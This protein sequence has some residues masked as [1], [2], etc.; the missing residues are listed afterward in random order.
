MKRYALRIEYDGTDFIGWQYQK[1]G[2]SV[3]AVVDS[4][5]AQAF[6]RRARTP[7]G[8]S[9]AVG[10]ARTDAGVHAQFQVAHLDLACDLA[11]P[12]VA[13]V[14]NEHLPADCAVRAAVAVPPDFHA[15]RD[16]RLKRYTYSLSD[17]ARPVIERRATAW[18][19]HPLDVS[20]MQEAAQ[21]WIGKHDF[22]AFRDARCEAKS[23]ERTISFIQVRREGHIL[24]VFEARS[25]LHRQVRI[26][27][28][29]LVEIGR[30]AK[31]AAW[32]KERLDGRVRA[33]SGPAMP[34]HG[35]SLD[36]IGYPED[37]FAGA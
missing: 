19:P 31:A 18:V 1:V 28:G 37:L 25:F 8:P 36:F 30:G 14:L 21:A 34:A 10:A 12:A 3:Q 23:P 29:T 27:V 6:G 35:L 4:A 15:R 26:M 17:G 22:S 24:F 16:A 20:R 2:R 7:S 32:A 9:R 11:A 33:E 5:I 13:Q